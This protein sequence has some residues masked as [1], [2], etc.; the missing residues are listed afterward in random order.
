MLNVLFL[1]DQ[2]ERHR[3]FKKI[4]PEAVLTC[5]ANEAIWALGSRDFQVASLDH[6]LAYPDWKTQNNKRPYGAP[7][8]GSEVVE[9]I[10]KNRPKVER[11]WIHSHNRDAGWKMVTALRQARY[12]ALY[13]PF[14]YQLDRPGELYWGSELNDPTSR[15][16]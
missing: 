9:W 11:F 8:S 6:D 16:A 13:L 4:F 1:D 12:Q 15:P 14:S 2:F 10:V 5:T 3:I 7:G